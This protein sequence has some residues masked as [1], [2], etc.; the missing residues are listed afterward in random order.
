VHESDH[1][2][3]G[4]IV[5]ELALLVAGDAPLLA[6]GGE[7]LRL[8]HGVD[9]EVG[10]EVEVEVQHVRR[11]ACLLGDEGEDLVSHGI[12]GG[13]RCGGRGRGRRRGRYRRSRC[14]GRGRREIR[15]H[16]VHERDHVAERGIVAEL[17]LLVAGDAPLLADRGEQ[18]GLLDGVDAE[19]GL[20][21]EVEIQH[22]RRIARLLGHEGEDR[23]AH[24]IPGGGR[25]GGRRRG[26]R[27]GSRRRGHGLERGRREVRPHLVHERDHVAECRIVAELA[28]L[29]A[30][31]APFLADG[32]EQLGLLHGVDAEIGLEVEV[33]GEHVPRIARLLGDEGEDALLDRVRG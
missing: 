4:R 23:V 32:G 5:A 17:A 21:V 1:V 24:G 20:E 12:L 3:Q 26:R 15:P 25:C 2:A 13:R 18:L 6:D 16:L 29:V 31:D 22:V 14:L 7:E 11:I 33:E 28:L 8:L 19:V 30:G 9:A 27:R 10:L